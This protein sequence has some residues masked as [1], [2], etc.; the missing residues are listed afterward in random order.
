VLTLGSGGEVDE[1]AA[2]KRIHDDCKQANNT[3]NGSFCVCVCVCVCVV[4]VCMCARACVVRV[5]WCVEFRA[6]GNLAR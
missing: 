6:C 4:C 2:D 1:D 5:F 3:P